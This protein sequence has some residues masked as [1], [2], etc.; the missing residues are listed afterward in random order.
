MID[1]EAWIPDPGFRI[2]SDILDYVKRL[3]IR[4]K[5]VRFDGKAEMRDV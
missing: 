2:R 3:L 5:A 1:S 4:G